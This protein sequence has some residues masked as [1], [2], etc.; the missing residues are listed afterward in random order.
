MLT[1]RSIHVQCCV[2]ANEQNHN[3]QFIGTYCLAHEFE[4]QHS[5]SVEPITVY[6]ESSADNPHNASPTQPLLPAWLPDSPG[7]RPGPSHSQIYHTLI[8]KPS[9]ARKYDNLAG[10]PEPSLACYDYCQPVPVTQ[11]TTETQSTQNDYDVLFND[12][13]YSEITPEYSLAAVS[14]TSTTPQ[15]THRKR[16]L[17][18]VQSISYDKL[19]SRHSSVYD[20]AYAHVT[21]AHNNTIDLIGLAEGGAYEVDSDL[22]SSLKKRKQMIDEG[23]YQIPTSTGQIDLQELRRHHS[24]SDLSKILVRHYPYQSIDCVTLKPENSYATLTK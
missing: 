21:T 12:P 10:T 1:F 9:E 3:P 17:G 4:E 11:A 20:Y 22:V 15:H 8:H 19:N 23:H 24:D 18:M 13:D 5:V 6:K 14:D 7:M 16:S 2:G